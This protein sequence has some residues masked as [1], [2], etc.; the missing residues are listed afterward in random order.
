M[1]AP[2]VSVLLPTRNRADVLGLAI[3]SVL[4]QTMPD[5]EVLIV[6]DGCTDRTAAVVAGF[7]D[8]RLRWFDL[9]RAP[10]GGDANR[11]IALREA[12]G[13]AVAYARQD[14]LWLPDHLASLLDTLTRTDAEWAYSRPLWVGPDGVIC[15]SAVDLT[16]ADEVDRFLNH[17]NS[18]PS[19]NVMHWRSAIERMGHWPED[20]PDS[21]D[22]LSWQRILRRGARPPGYH[23]DATCLHFR[24]SARDSDRH[25]DRVWRAIAAAPGWPRVL[26]ASP[27]DE[28]EQAALWRVMTET[29]GWAGQMR[30]GTRTVLDRLAWRTIRLGTPSIE[31]AEAGRST[32]E[33]A[34]RL[35]IANGARAL[36][37]EQARSEQARCQND[38]LSERAAQLAIQH[39]DERARTEEAHAATAARVALLEQALAAAQRCIGRRDAQIDAAI[40]CARAAAADATRAEWNA[41]Q[42]SSAGQSSSPWRITKFRR[43]ATALRRLVTRPPALASAELH[44]A[45]GA[46]GD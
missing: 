17:G 20:R 39:A 12:R 31:S 1:A 18:V 41:G 19:S 46:T 23:P 37:N 25:A 38:E 16:L 34:T 4:A 43:L 5:F 6:G 24:A 7:D 28:T 45:S 9:P 27:Q 26:H 29:P 44:D 42:I 3:Q 35:A 13:E 14:D 2:R 22:W 21:A 8:R 11:T 32:A 36:V 40:A 10:P 30:A 15:P 33:A